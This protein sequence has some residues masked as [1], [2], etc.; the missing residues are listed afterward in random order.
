[1]I[2]LI[3][4]LIF[5]ILTFLLILFPVISVP[6]KGS[7]FLRN[8]QLP[9]TV[10]FKLQK[11][12]PS[13]IYLMN[14]FEYMFQNSFGV[15]FFWTSGFISWILSCYFWILQAELVSLIFILFSIILCLLAIFDISDLNLKR[16]SNFRRA[17]L[18]LSIYFL[19]TSISVMTMVAF[20]SLAAGFT[21]NIVLFLFVYTWGV[22]K[23]TDI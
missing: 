23:K 2:T 10:N 3:H 15:H 20:K 14:L 13:L 4:L 21:T 7:I 5:I 6:K 8:F 22:Y 19:I 18:G 17:K 12:V 16:F 9:K 11:V 1:L